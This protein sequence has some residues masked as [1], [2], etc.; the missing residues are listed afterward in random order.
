MTS[1]HRSALLPYRARQLFDL[2]NDIEAYPAY[3]DGCV[4]AQILRREADLVEA[5]LDLAK[6]VV[7]Q[8]FATRNR[9]VDERH[10]SLELVEGPFDHFRG[11]WEFLPL[12]EAACKVSLELEFRV[13]SSLLGAAAARLFDSVSDNLVSAV[14]RRARQL[15]G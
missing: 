6:G 12:G 13:R 2:V 10:I 9:L 7:S 4:G 11:S 5:R 1:I 14:E 8:S 3:M 15:Y